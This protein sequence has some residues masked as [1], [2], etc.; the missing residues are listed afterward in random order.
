MHPVPAVVVR[1]AATPVPGAATG[2]RSRRAAGPAGARRR[3]GS[4][5]APARRRAGRTRRP[6]AGEGAAGPG[7]H[8]GQA[9]RRVV[10]VAAR[11]RPARA[12]R[13]PSA[14]SGRSGR[15]WA[16]AGDD[17]QRQRETAAQLAQQVAPPPRRPPRA[18]SPSRSASSDAGLGVG[19]HVQAQR[20]GRRA[21]RPG[22]RA[23]CG[24]S[25]GRCRSA[26]PGSSGTTW[27]V[28]AALSS[29]SS[30]RLPATMLRNRPSCA[31]RLVR[32]RPGADAQCV[33][34]AAHRRRRVHRRARP[35]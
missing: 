19:Q 2:P 20:A 12:A 13:R 28:S 26:P 17:A 27:A 23:G 33:E 11:Q 35:G 4:R 32:H 16:R 6:A 18:S 10:V 9:G 5:P 31:C 14:A 1:A 22:R 24:W 30:S 25:P 7:E 15:V 34:E 29:T 8:G 3:A 21:G